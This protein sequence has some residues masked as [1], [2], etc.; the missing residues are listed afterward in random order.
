MEKSIQGSLDEMSIR[1]DVLIRQVASLND[2]LRK[3]KLAELNT[4]ILDGNEAANYLK[5][6]TRFLQKL[7]DSGEIKF[8]QRDL[9]IRY[10]KSDLDKWLNSYKVGR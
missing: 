2:G 5:V 6:T 3:N 7:R 10:K 1:I 8:Y 9:L 4:E